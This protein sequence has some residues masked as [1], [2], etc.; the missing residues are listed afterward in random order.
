MSVVPF[1]LTAERSTS[2][3]S[4]AVFL[5]SAPVGS[6]AIMSSGDLTTARA[7]ATRCF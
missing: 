5:S 1:S 3:I 2:V 6:S 7:I 4:S